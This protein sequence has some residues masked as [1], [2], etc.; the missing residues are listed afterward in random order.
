M[1]DV[2]TAPGRCAL[3]AGSPASAEPV[4]PLDLADRAGVGVIRFPGRD[5]KLE[6]RPPTRLPD[7]TPAREPRLDQPRD[8][9]LR[10]SPHRSGPPANVR[11]PD[12]R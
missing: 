5:P 6:D 8:R 1:S 7:G 10:G 11:V 4:A 9:Q 2:C 12:G 3:S